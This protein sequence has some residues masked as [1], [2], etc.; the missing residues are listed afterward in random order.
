MKVYVTVGM[1]GILNGL[2]MNAYSTRE[3]AER[4]IKDNLWQMEP[5]PEPKINELEVDEN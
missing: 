1:N 5:Q 4:G 2:I 3:K